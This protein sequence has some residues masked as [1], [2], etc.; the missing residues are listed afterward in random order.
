MAVGSPLLMA[1]TQLRLPHEMKD[2]LV[3][4]LDRLPTRLRVA[5]AAAYAERQMPNYERFLPSQVSEANPSDAAASVAYAIEAP[6]AAADW[7]VT[8]KL[9]PDVIDRAQAELLIAHPI[10]QAEIHRQH[11]DLQDL[12]AAGRDDEAIAS[13]VAEVRDRARQDAASFLGDWNHGP[14]QLDE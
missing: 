14:D 9:Q 3:V 1:M 6:Y 10:G 5:F 7:V 11:A 13:V 12:E 8:T 2:G 4:T